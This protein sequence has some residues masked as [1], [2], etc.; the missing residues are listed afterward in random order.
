MRRTIQ[1]PINQSTTSTPYH[2][3]YIQVT[4]THMNHLWLYPVCLSL[5]LLV[6]CVIL[7]L[8]LR[9]SKYK[10]LLFFRFFYL[11]SWDRKTGW[12]IGYLIGQQL[13]CCRKY[14]NFSFFQ[15]RSHATFVIPSRFIVQQSAFKFCLTNLTIFHFKQIL[16]ADDKRKQKFI[17]IYITSFTLRHRP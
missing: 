11:N 7:C 3:P 16:L 6:W 10:A 4:D 9:K 8:P 14:S 12:I 13:F 17:I 2:Q 1:V 5:Y 15:C